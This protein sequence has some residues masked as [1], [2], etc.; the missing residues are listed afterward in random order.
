MADYLPSSS[1][2]ASSSLASPRLSSPPK[3]SGPSSAAGF[4]FSRP[5]R[6]SIEDHESGFIS[7]LSEI[8]SRTLIKRISAEQ[9]LPFLEWYPPTVREAAKRPLFS[10]LLGIRADAREYS[11][12]QRA[13]NHRTEK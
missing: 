1:M 7:E 6:Y 2:A 11:L 12:M 10:V 13:P 5:R 8:E 9:L 3:G 4:F